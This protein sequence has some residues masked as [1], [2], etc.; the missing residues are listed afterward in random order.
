MLRSR[1]QSSVVRLVVA[2]AFAAAAAAT[3]KSSSN[4]ASGAGSGGASAASGGHGAAGQ[5]GA[6]EGAGG[7]QSAQGG[8][9]FV[10]DAMVIPKTCSEAET[11]AHDCADNMTCAAR[12][13]AA[14]TGHEKMLFDDMLNCRRVNCADP[15]DRD[16]RCM[17]DC[18]ADCPCADGVDECM[19]GAA[20]PWCEQF[21]H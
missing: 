2:M 14:L 16:C 10:P 13:P 4:D 18:Y 12:C 20:D 6:G 19:G 17:N 11:C 15:T 7:A 21:C 9:V 8:A 5:G 3:C 1:F